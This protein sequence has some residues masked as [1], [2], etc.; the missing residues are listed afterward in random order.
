MWLFL[1]ERVDALY[2]SADAQNRIFL[3]RLAGS[4]RLLL[5]IWRQLIIDQALLTAGSLA[6]TTVLSMVPALAV[7]FAF[8]KAFSSSEAMVTKITNWLLDSLLAD[9]VSEMR[10]V[11]FGFLDRSDSGTVGTVGLLV[12]FG[13]AVSTFSAVEKAFNR[14]WRVPAT[15]PLHIR[16]TTYYAVLTLTPGLIAASFLATGWIKGGL[17]DSFGLELASTVVP[18][19]L[20]ITALTLMYKLLPHGRVRWRSALIGGTTGA[21]GFELT[22]ALF[23]LYAT[24]VYHSSATA[25]IYG[26]FALIPI[27]FLWI[28]L[29][30]IMVLFGIE[31]AFVAQNHRRL[32][33]AVLIRRGREQG[34]HAV[35]TGYLLSRIFVE[36]ARR[37]R[38]A[39]GGVAAAVLAQRL[40]ITLDELEP[41]LRLLKDA[42]MLLVVDGVQDGL[43]IPGRPLDQVQLADLYALCE[44]G[45]YEAG[46]L[47]NTPAAGAVEDA[48]AA[49]Q[50]RARSALRVS[51]LHILT[52]DVLAAEPT[53]PIDVSAAPADS[54]P[55]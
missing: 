27:F 43:L 29:A 10:E 40:Q 17:S 31:M 41:A 19:A 16:L 4:A 9:S 2:A 3:R 1:R 21:I 39:G 5:D 46:E 30:W 28:Y 22:K 20:E 6:F 25:K 51:V 26:S 50:E 18:F 12:L 48:A 47:P 32:S 54:T 7:F 13:T 52:K 44:G 35:P 45:G 36:V 33:Q 14:I 37:F 53:V 11:I 42:K 8:A 23:N 49:A 55:R 38:T 34:G 15:R 24:S